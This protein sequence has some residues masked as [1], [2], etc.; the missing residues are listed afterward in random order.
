[1]LCKSCTPRPKRTC[2]YCGQRR[3]VAANW[4]DGPACGSCYRRF[5]RAKSTCRLRPA[6]AAAAVCRPTAAVCA[7]CAGAP[8]GP[9]CGQ[10]GNEDWLYHKDRCARCVLTDRLTELLGDPDNR[11]RLG[12]QPLFDSL[13]HA[14]RP[15]AII[16]WTRPSA[17]GTAHILLA[18][19]GRGETP[20]THDALDKLNSPGNG[21][22]ANHL[23]AILTAIRALPPRDLELARLEH[24]IPAALSAV[25]DAEQRNVPRGYA[26]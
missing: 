15:E 2:A 12:L 9:V 16:G 22:T 8:P 4:A 21:G 19:L 14:E 23:D 6:P 7:S 10:C 20:L 24:A 5:M 13:V 1:M 18:Q 26:T 3:T 17:K 11:T 25:D